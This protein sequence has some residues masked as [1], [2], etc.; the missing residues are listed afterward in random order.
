MNGRLKKKKKAATPTVAVEG[1]KPARIKH[2]PP[3]NSK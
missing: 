3:S 1:L 2:S